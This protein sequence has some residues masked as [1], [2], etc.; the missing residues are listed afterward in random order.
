MKKIPKDLKQTLG[1]YS[2][3]F[4]Y[5]DISEYVGLVLLLHA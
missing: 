2:F 1:K 4:E 5:K 3:E